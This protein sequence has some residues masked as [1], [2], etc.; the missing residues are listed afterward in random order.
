MRDDP[1]KFAENVYGAVVF[2]LVL[3][4]LH[5]SS[6]PRDGQDPSNGTI[7]GFATATT[8]ASSKDAA[9]P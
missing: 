4:A 1:Y 8:A 3:V 6:G 7:R 5:T 2:I 9:P